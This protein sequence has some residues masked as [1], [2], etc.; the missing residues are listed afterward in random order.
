M[1]SKLSMNILTLILC[2]SLMPGYLMAGK[3]KDEYD[4]R[5]SI[6][7]SEVPEAITEKIKKILPKL[8]V[9]SVQ[10]VEKRKKSYYLVQGNDGDKDIDVLL[11]ESGSVV[12]LKR[13]PNS[14]CGSGG[15]S[16]K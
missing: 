10:K 1:P 6:P 12:K 14:S 15:C 3:D 11:R 5:V 7:K 4:S 13:K 16:R 9:N 8:K 2:L